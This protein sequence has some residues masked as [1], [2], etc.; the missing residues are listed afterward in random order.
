MTVIC[1][2]NL[3]FWRLEFAYFREKK[4]LNFDDLARPEK[5]MAI[6]KHGPQSKLKK[7]LQL[8]KQNIKT[9]YTNRL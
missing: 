8:R 2:W 4:D 6:T 7:L 3:L 1:E 9:V 5:K